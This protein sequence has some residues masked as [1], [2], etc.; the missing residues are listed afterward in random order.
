MCIM[1]YDSFVVV[2]ILF[3]LC[4]ILCKLFVYYLIFMRLLRFY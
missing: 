4:F 3:V 2:F 1:C